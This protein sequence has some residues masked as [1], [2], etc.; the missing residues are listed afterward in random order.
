MTISEWLDAREPR[1]PVALDGR[2]RVAIGADLARDVADVAPVCVAA[3]ERTLA[4]LLETTMMQR[5]HAFELLAADALLTYAFES[6]ADDPEHLAAFAASTMVRL[7]APA[8]L[9]REPS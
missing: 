3:A 4:T 6:A 2:V 5:E 8:S 7:T 1:P 9:L